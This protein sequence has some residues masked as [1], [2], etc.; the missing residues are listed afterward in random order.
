MKAPARQ[1]KPAEKAKR[2]ALSA[3]AKSHPM[4]ADLYRQAK[5]LV[6]K[7]RKHPLPDPAAPPPPE[8][9]PTRLLH[10]LQVHQVELELQNVELQESRDRME[11]LLEEYTDLYDFAPVG[12]FTLSPDGTILQANLTG[13]RLAAVDRA[14]LVGQRFGVLVAPKLRPRFAAFLEQVFAGPAKQS[15]DFELVQPG[16]SPR[17]VTFEAQRSPNGQECRAAAMDITARRQEEEKVRV[18]E[19]RYR[20]LFEAAHDGVLLLDPATAQITDA[21]PF[22]TKLLGYP[23]DQ[24]V[25]KELFEIGLLKDEAASREMFRK[26]RTNHQV[27]YEDLPLET[28]G[29]NLREVEV[30][31]NLYQENGRS[32]IQC[33]VRDI[34]E[35]KGAELHLRRSEALFAALIEQAPIGTYVVDSQFRLQHVNP[36]AQP[37]FSKIHPVLGRDFSEVIRLLWPDKIARAVV[38]RFRHTLKSGEP[39]ASADFSARRRD[40]GVREYYEW[41]IQRVTLPGGEYGVVCFFN[42][43]TDRK[44]AE[45]VQRR[46]DILAAS[47]KKLELE[48]R[49]RQAVQASLKESERHQRRCTLE[50]RRL[51]KQLRLMSRQL[52][53]VQEEERKRI[54]RELHDVIAQ[55]LTGIDL[56]LANLNKQAALDAGSLHRHVA[57]T[58]LQVG[59]AIEI[60]HRFALELRPA[61]LDDLGLIPALHSFL[62]R[63]AA[64]TGLHTHLTAF[65]GLAQLDTARRTTLFRVAQ[66]A[67]LNVSRHAQAS[68]VDVRIEQQPGGICMKIADD[69]ASFEVERV[70]RARASQH[71]GLIGMRERLEMI[72][73]SF[74]IESA[75]GRG[76]TVTAQIPIRGGGGADG[77][78]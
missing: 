29:G 64:R 33:N 69:G 1:T 38:H 76:T 18:S 35:R 63:F 61:A 26:L 19:I 39:Y 58:Q 72:G 10:E 14:R 57:R 25:G 44:R 51:Q 62:K 30:V 75:P 36:K 78:R 68:R 15:C 60:V 27:R 7:R 77:I 12:Y 5:V 16:P 53:R 23:R 56:L 22:M 70:M 71:L 54:S 24:L 9:S 41:Q 73:G 13:A 28:L 21:N 6:R 20:R 47:N 32:M 50:A 49:H 46:L 65:A 66:E 17:I 43:I 59:H 42:D 74:A 8:A 11:S 31:A 45:G 37:V 40:L 3:Q 55:T 52:L 2:S 48:I 34:T 4:L 67:L